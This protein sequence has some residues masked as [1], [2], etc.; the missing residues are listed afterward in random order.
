MHPKMMIAL[1][2]EV[3]RDRL[4]ERHK[5]QLRSQ[6]LVDCSQDSSRGRTT[7]GLVRRLL[8]GISVRPGLS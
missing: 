6:A 5:L 2:H 3:E 4:N 8:A 7:N 1:A